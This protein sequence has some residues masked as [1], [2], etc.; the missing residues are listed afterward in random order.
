MIGARR[1]RLQITRPGLRF[2]HSPMNDFPIPEDPP[3][4]TTDEY[5]E[6]TSLSEDTGAV[7]FSSEPVYSTVSAQ[8][9]PYAET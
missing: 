7:R 1:E 6:R 4:M 9:K 8:P 2:A 5:G 3:V